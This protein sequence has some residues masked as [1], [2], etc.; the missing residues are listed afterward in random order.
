MDHRIKLAAALAIGLICNISIAATH[1]AAH[2]TQPLEFKTLVL[3]AP[4]TPAQVEA[5]LTTPCGMK[6]GTCDDLD[7]KMQEDRKVTC[8]LGGGGMQV[9]NGS[10][11]IADTIAEVNVVIGAD[12]ILQRIHL[13]F[14]NLGYDDAQQALTAKFGKAQRVS[15]PTLQNGFGA[16]FRQEESLWTGANGAQLL[17]N[18]YAADT[19]HSDAYFSNKED[20]DLLEGKSRA[21]SSDL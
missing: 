16:T 9:C 7:K 5:V 11:T 17:L 18:E 13:T 10:T 20:R 21:A 19:D 15:H 14:S 6:G 1:H 3:G 4:T 2:P 8:G 12:G